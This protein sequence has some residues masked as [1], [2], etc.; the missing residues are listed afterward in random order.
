MPT[1]H[2]EEALLQLRG[3]V[4]DVLRTF[5]AGRRQ[6][7]AR[8]DPAAAPLADEIARLVQAGGRRVRPA[9]VYWGFRAAGG[10]D[11]APILDAAAA[12]ELLHTMALIHDDLM[13]HAETR[14]GVPASHVV[15]G[16]SEAILAG[17]LAAVFADQLLLRSG[18]AP[19][20]LLAAQGRYHRMRVEMAAGQYLDLTGASSDPHHV[21]ALKGGSYTVTGPLLMGADLAGGGT[22]IV[23][24]LGRYG[25]PLGRAFQLLDDLRD[26]EA[27]EGVTRGV[28]EALVEEAVAALDADVLGAEA[29]GALTALARLVGTT[30]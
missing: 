16:V 18:F 10:S 26:G 15:V 29:T 4:D 25:E 6:D 8:I 9:F 2:A 23:T 27:A 22:P 12:L 17:D 28:A 14:R 24:R 3:R 19:V 20:R 5:L 13:D 30:T 1:T 11:G 7:L 21:A